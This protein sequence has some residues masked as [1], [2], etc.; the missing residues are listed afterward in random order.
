MSGGMVLFFEDEGGTPGIALRV[1]GATEARAPETPRVVRLA[2]ATAT[3]PAPPAASRRV[4]PARPPAL[5]A[6]EVL[7]RRSA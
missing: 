7:L 3:P 5:P 2:A 4:S 6:S 1:R